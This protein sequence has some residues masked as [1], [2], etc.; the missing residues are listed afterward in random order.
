VDTQPAP[1]LFGAAEALC[2]TIAAPRPARYWNHYQ[3]GVAAA[4][5]QLDGVTFAAAWAAGRAL[6]LEQAI[7]EA[8]KATSSAAA[9]SQPSTTI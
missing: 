1:R 2:E 8:L 3:R 5:A 6:T 7:A 4:R 9:H